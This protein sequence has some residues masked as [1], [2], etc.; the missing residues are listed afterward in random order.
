MQDK[1][2][3]LIGQLIFKE[4]MEKRNSFLPPAGF[5]LSELVNHVVAF[6]LQYPS[7]P[8]DAILEE[9]CKAMNTVKLG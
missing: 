3:M 9:T 5:L 6:S 4:T 2:S 8:V 7:L 1:L